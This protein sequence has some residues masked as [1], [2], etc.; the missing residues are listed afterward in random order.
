MRRGGGA[1]STSCQV[2]HDDARRPRWLAKAIGKI[3]AFGNPHR[4]LGI[5]FDAD[6]D[7][8]H[9]AHFLVPNSAAQPRIALLSWVRGDQPLADTSQH[10]GR[11]LLDCLHGHERHGRGSLPR[12]APRRPARRS[13]WA[14]RKPSHVAGRSASPR[15]RVCVT[16]APSNAPRRSFPRR[17]S[18]S[19]GSTHATEE[20]RF[21]VS[22][23]MRTICFTDGSLGTLMP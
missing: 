21:E 6:P 20:I 23:P 14:R 2:E 12:T 8:L 5:V 13:C 22:I 10:Q 4:G 19:A 11:L 1:S 16:P 7:G 17:T 15:G 3:G 9:S 18:R